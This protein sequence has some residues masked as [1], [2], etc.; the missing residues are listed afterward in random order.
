MEEMWREYEKLKPAST[1]RRIELWKFIQ[2]LKDKSP[3]EFGGWLW[4]Q[5]VRPASKIVR[6]IDLW[7]YTVEG[8]TESVMRIKREIKEGKWEIKE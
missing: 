1:I 2:T 5:E 8:D 7:N 6:A 4:V 3:D